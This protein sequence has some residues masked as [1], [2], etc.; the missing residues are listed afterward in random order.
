VLVSACRE[1]LL[2]IV[3]LVRGQLTKLQRAT[4]GALVV[5]DVHARDVVTALADNNVTNETDFD[6]QAQLR[7]YWV[8]DTVGDRGHTLMMNMMS[9]EI[10]FGCDTEPTV[11]LQYCCVACV[12]GVSCCSL[13]GVIIVILVCGGGG[14]AAAALVVVDIV[15]II[16]IMFV[17]VYQI[18]FWAST[19]HLPAVSQSITGC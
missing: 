9:A 16:A 2:K 7:S 1:N 13:A 17:T 11:L 4:L 6:W 5:M 18:A 8:A 3:D 14:A 12:W 19:L 15:A 10:E